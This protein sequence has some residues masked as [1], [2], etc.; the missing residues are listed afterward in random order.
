MVIDAI[1]RRG[2]VFGIGYHKTG[3]SS[4]AIALQILG[5]A[6]TGPRGV[7][8][9]Q[10]STRALPI[11][12]DLVNQYDAFQDNPWPLLYKE[13]DRFVPNSKFILTVRPSDSWI[14]SVVR[15]FGGTST[16]MRE[17]IY[18]VGDPIGNEAEYVRRYEAHNQSVFQYFSQQPRDLL[19][20]DITRGASWEQLCEFLG[21]RA[22]DVPFPVA[23]TAEWRESWTS[24]GL[25][26]P[27]WKVY[28]VR[29][30]PGIDR[31]GQ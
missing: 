30:S 24:R 9:P 22:P 28:D 29:K 20:I 18:G 13:L 6:V 12:L 8:D 14:R 3:T 10:I 27:D 19:V 1:N 5:Y 17:W 21:N 11:V 25:E 7:F 16:P 23:N 15:H 4:L 2:K 31:D 26:C